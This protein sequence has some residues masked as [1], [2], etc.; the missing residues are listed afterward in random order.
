MITSTAVNFD[1][2]PPIT[3]TQSATVTAHV[4]S[5]ARDEADERDILGVLGLPG[6]RIRQQVTSLRCGH[7]ST[8]AHQRPGRGTECR[9]CNRGRGSGRAR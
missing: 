7:P 9:A 1:D 4:H 3:P 6:G 5:A 2:V 8:E